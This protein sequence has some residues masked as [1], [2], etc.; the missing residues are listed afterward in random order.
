MRYQIRAFRLALHMQL[1]SWKTWIL[2]LLL[3]GVTWSL[4]AALPAQAVVSPVQV[5]VCL[6]DEGAEAFWEALEN[7]SGT[8]TTFIQADEDTII[9]KVTTGQWD[10]GIVLPE[11]FA[12][13]VEEMDTHEL[14]GLYISDSSTVYPIV[15][16]TVAACLI[17]AAGEGIAK[18][19]LEE[20]GF[21]KTELE[22]KPL[23]ED[24]RVDI[25]M[26][27]VD[28]RELDALALSEDTSG[29]IV[30]GILGIVLTIRMLLTAVDLGRWLEQPCVVRMAPLRS[31]TQRLLPQILASVVPV[32]VSAGVS[33][34]IYSKSLQILLPLA[35]YLL[36]MCAWLPVLARTKGIRS[37]VPILMPFVPVLCLVLSPIILD[38]GA[39]IPA[40][41]Q[42]S[43]WLPLTLYLDAAEGNLRCAA[44]LLQIALVGM[45]LC[46][47]LDLFET[48]SLRS[49]HMKKKV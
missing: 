44:V 42:I 36:A 8:V 26:S 30:M 4:S 49:K 21:A 16:E 2:L 39:M 23:S 37:A 38:P 13:R 3:P 40:M 19:Y 48:G 35:A 17:S 41:G 9:G 47:V 46:P 14:I 25:Q 10:C 32:F 33:V 24:E 15:R 18:E 11:D 34:C 5:G 27:T 7:R 6:P 45:L 20:Q 29:R 1:R 31:T 22:V 12:R 28:G 43:K